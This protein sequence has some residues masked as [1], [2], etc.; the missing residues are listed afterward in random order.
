MSKA[1]ILSELSNLTTAEL[2]EIQA[3][4]DELVGE[5]WLDGGELTGDD[6]AAL[7]AALAEYQK[8][9]GAGSSWE[10]AEA[11]IRAKLRP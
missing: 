5:V 11:R 7:D 6:Q 4:L 1:D 10:E 3:R 9:P 2:I 8:N